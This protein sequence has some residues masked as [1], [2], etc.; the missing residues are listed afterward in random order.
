[1]IILILINALSSDTIPNN[2]HRQ[3]KQGWP[4]DIFMGGKS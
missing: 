2:P 1:M 3:L 4:R